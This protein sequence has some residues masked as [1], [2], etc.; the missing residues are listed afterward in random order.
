M[1]WHMHHWTQWQYTVLLEWVLS[2]GSSNVMSGICHSTG[3]QDAEGCWLQLVRCAY[4]LVVS[5]YFVYA[6]IWVGNMGIDFRD[7]MESNETYRDG[8]VVDTEG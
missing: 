5:L 8:G 4:P 7:V 6:G 2:V 1:C 3:S